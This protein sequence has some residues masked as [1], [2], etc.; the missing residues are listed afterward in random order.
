MPCS[1]SNRPAR[2]RCRCSRIRGCA[3]TPEDLDRGFGRIAAWAERIGAIAQLQAL[4]GLP[5]SD[6]RDV[7]AQR[8][9]F[10]CGMVFAAALSPPVP[11]QLRQLDGGA[12]AVSRHIGAYAG[13]EDALDL[14]LAQWLP[15]SG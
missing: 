2:L 5:L 6:H 3:D 7:P 12:H 13:V 11:L 1:S 15:H 4:I 10:E 14:L 9:L 8:H